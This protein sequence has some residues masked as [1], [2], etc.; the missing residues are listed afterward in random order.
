[1]EEVI[2]PTENLESNREK[3][4]VEEVTT[5]SDSTRV[6]TQQPK[7]NT[8]STLDT[9][10]D[11]L[12]EIDKSY[13]SQYPVYEDFENS[14]PDYKDASIPT[15]EQIVQEAENDL[16]P[17]RVTNQQEIVN[18]YQNDLASLDLRE[19][20]INQNLE[21][22]KQELENELTTGLENNQANQINQGIERS[23]IAQNMQ[24]SLRNSINTELEYEIQRANNSL[25]E[26]DLQRELTRNEMN[27]ALEK[28]DI[29]YAS[30]LEDKIAELN[31]QYEQLTIDLNK[32]NAE[33]SEIRNKRIQEWQEWADS[34][35]SRL[36]A[37]KGQEKSVYIIDQLKGLTKAEALRIL[38]DADIKA[39]LGGWYSSVLDY[40]NRMM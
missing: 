16:L 15:Q 23:S 36:D 33:I 38:N 27:S 34:F 40:V 37:Q 20:T 3:I 14:L 1:M 31:K 11:R 10:K 28:F 19:N 22:T 8:S 4:E 32:Y 39:S 2:M 17:Y 35:T 7:I 30:E 6:A 24:T 18:E 26:I 9:V 29:A 5:S 12:N 13:E 25:A 21:Q